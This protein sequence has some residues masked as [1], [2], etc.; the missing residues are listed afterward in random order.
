MTND[1]ELYA[2]KLLAVQQS[3]TIEDLRTSNKVNR[4]RTDSMDDGEQV[5][6]R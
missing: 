1:E 3:R 5:E 2:T 6:V 4:E